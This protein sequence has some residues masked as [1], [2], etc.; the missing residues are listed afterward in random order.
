MAEHLAHRDGVRIVGSP[1]DALVVAANSGLAKPDVRQRLR[2]MHEGKAPLLEI[3][4]AV[5]LGAQMTPAVRDLL[6]NLPPDVVEGIRRATLDMLDRD[7][8]TLPL[9][10]DVTVADVTAGTAV[11]VTVPTVDNQRTI[12]VRART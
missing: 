10:C 3:V 4:D 11:D 6:A 1:L 12:T 2:S 8:T 9:D 7:A 5:G